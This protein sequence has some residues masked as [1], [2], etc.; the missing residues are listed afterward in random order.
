VNRFSKKR[1]EF[2]RKMFKLYSDLD[3]VMLQAER[4]FSE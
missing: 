4:Y 1:C 2:F 3:P